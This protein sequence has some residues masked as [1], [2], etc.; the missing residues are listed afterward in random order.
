MDFPLISDED[1]PLIFNAFI[2]SICITINQTYHFFGEKDVATHRVQIVVDATEG[3]VSA[4]F[5]GASYFHCVAAEVLAHV[6]PYVHLWK[7]S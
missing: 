6:H 4:G 7:Q 1:V 3:N 5:R 2:L